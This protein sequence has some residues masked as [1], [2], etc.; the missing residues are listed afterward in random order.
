MTTIILSGCCG[1]L[2][3]AIINAA[4]N[5]PDLSIVAG[6]DIDETKKLDFPVFSSFSKLPITADVIVDVSHPSALKGLL[7][8]AIEKNIPC[9]LAPTGYG[10][11]HHQMIANAANH[12]P[13]FHTSNLSIG[14]NLLCEI[15]KACAK[16][17]GNNF[18]IEIVE[19]H[20]NKKLDAPSGTALMLADALSEGLSYEPQYVYDR[21]S[22]RN[23][24][25]KE[26]IGLHSVRGGTIPGE[27]TVIFAGDDE[28]IKLSHTALSKT[29]FALGALN[30][31]E[32]ISKQEIGKYSM[33]DMLA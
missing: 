31:A 33:A 26:E 12:I 21:H 4:K 14:I 7:E 25:S 2:G 24:R 16:V 20:H 9:V 11:G 18:D 29:V 32:F 15:S 1:A 5:R 22:V 28:I 23:R 8:F 6:V 30:A 17:L 3:T 13:I 19:A 27:H 10:E